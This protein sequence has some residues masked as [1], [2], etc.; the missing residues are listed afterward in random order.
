[1]LAKG[2]EME[3]QAYQL[4]VKIGLVLRAALIIAVIC[5]LMLAAYANGVKQGQHNEPEKI[6]KPVKKVVDKA[7][8]IRHKVYI[9]NEETVPEFAPTGLI[10]PRD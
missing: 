8:S 4:G 7:K 10:G 3:N 5:F 2:F 9:A 6:T 1:M